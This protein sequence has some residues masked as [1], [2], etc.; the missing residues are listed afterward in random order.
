[1]SNLSQ[2][3]SQRIAANRAYRMG[4]PHMTDSDFDQLDSILRAQLPA[5][6]YAFAH[7]DSFESDFQTDAPLTI[8]M[9]SQNKALTRTALL[10]ESFVL[11]HELHGS[12]K[13]DGQSIELTYRDFTLTRGITRGDDGIVGKDVSSVIDLVPSIPRTLANV[14]SPDW[15]I[16]G[17]LYLTK[18]A[19]AEINAILRAQG[20]EEF[21]N[22]RNSVSSITRT[23]KHIRFARFLSFMAFDMDVIQ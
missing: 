12:H 21:A 5:D 9:G 15:V 17:E 10:K 22:T 18:S 19:L 14:S 1:M 7:E 8:H 13:I 3:I 23:L 11:T 4:Q 6:H 16:R 2:L 20:Q